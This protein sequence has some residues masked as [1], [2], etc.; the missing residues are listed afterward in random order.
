MDHIPMQGGKPLGMMPAPIIRKLKEKG[1]FGKHLSV[2][3]IEEMMADYTE[4]GYM[5]YKINSNRV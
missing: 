3:S 4:M 5:L 2:H 1:I